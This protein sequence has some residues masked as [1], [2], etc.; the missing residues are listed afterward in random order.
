MIWRILLSSYLNN[1]NTNFDK[2]WIIRILLMRAFRPYILCVKRN[3]DLIQLLINIPYKFQSSIPPLKLAGLRAFS[4]ADKYVPSLPFHLIRTWE[5]IY[6]WYLP[7]WT[8]VQQESSILL[9]RNLRT[10]MKTSSYLLWICDIPK[11]LVNIEGPSLNQV[12]CLS[13]YV[14]WNDYTCIVEPWTC[15]R[16]ER[17]WA[18]R[19]SG[20]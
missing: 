16:S 9:R 2:Y 8:Q 17:G 18:W 15:R 3:L 11:W 6:Q 10:L 19:W 4:K 5:K 7:F 12:K 13:P 1:G 20:P 14:P